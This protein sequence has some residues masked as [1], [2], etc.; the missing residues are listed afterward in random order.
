MEYKGIEL[1][2]DWTPDKA[3]SYRDMPPIP[4]IYAELHIKSYGVRIGMSANLKERH[5]EAHG[6]FNKM[7][8]GTARERDQK[9]NN[10]HCQA[11]KL[12]GA[13]GFAHFIISTDPRL[14]DESLRKE[15]ETYLFQWVAQS[16]LYLDFNTQRGHRNALQFSTIEQAIAYH[17]SRVPQENDNG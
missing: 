16:P 12:D 2:M 9:R 13:S 3:V 14:S 15:V 7:Q 6:W 11:A 10:V 8:A 17:A 1:N 4:G 5:N